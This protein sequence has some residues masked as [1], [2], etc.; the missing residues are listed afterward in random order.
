VTDLLALSARD[1][2]S[3]FWF[4]LLNDGLYYLIFLFNFHLLFFWGAGLALP[5]FSCLLLLQFFLLLLPIQFL[6][7]FLQHLL[8]HFYD[9]PPLLLELGL[10]PLSL[11]TDCLHLPWSTLLLALLFLSLLELVLLLPILD[12]V[13]CFLDAWPILR[14]YRLS[15]SPLI[16]QVAYITG[17]TWSGA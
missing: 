17:F 6:P 10:L 5:L 13:L 8:L 15:F 1:T 12:E 2:R 16:L 14:F 11:L 9:L 3:S 7:L 4:P